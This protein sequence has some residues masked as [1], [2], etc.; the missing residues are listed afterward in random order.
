MQEKLLYLAFT[1]DMRWSH[2]K[3]ASKKCEVYLFSKLQKSC[4]VGTFIGVIVRAMAG[5]VNKGVCPEL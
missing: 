4:C 2:G 3:M 5:E 1:F